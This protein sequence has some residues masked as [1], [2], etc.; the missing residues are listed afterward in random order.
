MEFYP[1]TDR[2]EFDKKYAFI[3]GENHQMLNKLL[4]EARHVNGGSF[5]VKPVSKEVKIREKKFPWRMRT[6]TDYEYIFYHVMH[7]GSDGEECICGYAWDYEKLKWYF[8][9]ISGGYCMAKGVNLVYDK[10]TKEI[11]EI[12][13]KE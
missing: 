10:D 12:P 3:E 8:I 9:G 13:I 1:I 4:Q 2:V 6:F 7:N 11:K 5:W